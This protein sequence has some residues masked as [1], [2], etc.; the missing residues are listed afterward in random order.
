MIAA[1][2]MMSSPLKVKQSSSFSKELMI[3][4]T[5]LIEMLVFSQP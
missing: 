2:L 5:E 3:S 1:T 4:A